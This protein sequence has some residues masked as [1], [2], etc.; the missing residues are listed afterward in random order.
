MPERDDALRDQVA[1]QVTEEGKPCHRGAVPGL[2]AGSLTVQRGQ[3]PVD[4]GV[5]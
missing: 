5:Q 2:V 4:G 3:C 1:V